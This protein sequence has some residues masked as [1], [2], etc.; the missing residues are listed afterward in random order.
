[1]SGTDVTKINLEL[2]EII[3]SKGGRVKEETTRIF[4]VL[5][6]LSIIDITI[7]R[8]AFLK[9]LIFLGES[10]E[11]LIKEYQ[12]VPDSDV[13]LETMAIFVIG[14]EDPFFSP[15]DIK[16]VIDGKQVL[17]EVPLLQQRL[18]CSLDSVMH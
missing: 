11:D 7:T 18:P 6:E 10:V 8:E 1:M 16:I 4:K 17:S 3:K 13:L 2:R 15:T 5:D 12:D 9:S 14:R